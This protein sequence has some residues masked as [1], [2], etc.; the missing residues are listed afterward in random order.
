VPLLKFKIDN[1]KNGNVSERG[2]H[3]EMKNRSCH[4]HHRDRD[5]FATLQELCRSEEKKTVCSRLSNSSKWGTLKPVLP[6]CPPLLEC[7]LQSDKSVQFA[8]ACT[9]PEPFAPEQQDLP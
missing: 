3:Y 1:T 7:L 8:L 9:A 6:A 4:C 5:N 2:K